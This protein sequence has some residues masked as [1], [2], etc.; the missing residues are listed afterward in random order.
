MVHVEP[1]EVFSQYITN[2]ISNAVTVV[3]V[4]SY[5]EGNEAKMGVS[6]NILLIY[7][8][9]IFYCHHISY[10]NLKQ[11]KCQ[12]LVVVHSQSEGDE[13]KLYEYFYRTRSTLR[14]DLWSSEFHKAPLKIQIFTT[15]L[16]ETTH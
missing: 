6:S 5:G 1:V 12:M 10:C 7:D 13:A 14:L 2:K 3:V 15:L 4:H 11:I 16:L 9:A 8:P